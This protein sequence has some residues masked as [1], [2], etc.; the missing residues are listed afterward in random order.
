MTEACF[1]L[2]VLLAWD[3]VHLWLSL[4]LYASNL[5]NSDS[6]M[7]Y[8]INFSF[9]G[10]LDQSVVFALFQMMICPHGFDRPL[11]S[12]YLMMSGGIYIRHGAAAFHY[13]LLF[14]WLF[15]FIVLLMA[16]I[17]TTLLCFSTICSMVIW[18]LGRSVVVFCAFALTPSTTTRR[19]NLLRLML[20]LII[21]TPTTNYYRRVLARWLLTLVA[22][23]CAWCNS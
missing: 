4:A 7:T 5:I 13:S 14:L 21:M 11:Y 12:S 6:C 19:S 10:K 22:S 17:L 2:L 18:L 1:L 3:S 16:S 9:V 23:G 15:C 20:L 8:L